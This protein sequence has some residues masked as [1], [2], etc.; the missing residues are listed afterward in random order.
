MSSKYEPMWFF[1]ISFV[2][3]KTSKLLIQCFLKPKFQQTLLWALFLETL[4][5]LLRSLKLPASGSLKLPSISF[6]TC[7][8]LWILIQYS[9]KAMQ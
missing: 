8:S 3:I 6:V 7:G 2:V 9:Y 1:P 4:P 5:Y